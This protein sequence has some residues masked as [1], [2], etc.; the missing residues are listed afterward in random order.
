MAVEQA[1]P[2]VLLMTPIGLIAAVVFLHETITPLQ[3]LG[4]AIL[5]LGLAIVNDLQKFIFGAGALKDA[6]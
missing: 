2:F 6:A 1:V 3:I 4:G 5:M